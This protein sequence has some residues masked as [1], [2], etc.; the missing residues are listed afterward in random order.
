MVTV[1]CPLMYCKAASKSEDTV[2]L[3]M[4]PLKREK[5]VL[6]PTTMFIGSEPVKFC[7]GG[8]NPNKR[9]QGVLLVVV[10]KLLFCLEKSCLNR[11]V[12]ESNYPCKM[13][14]GFSFANT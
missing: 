12:N 4:P 14:I 6:I 9:S 5:T 3:L 2:I 10:G 8:V 13:I 11:S 7:E 1:L